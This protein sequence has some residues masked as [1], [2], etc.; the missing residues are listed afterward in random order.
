MFSLA[1][2]LM[3]LSCLL[4][5]LVCAGI[6]YMQQQQRNAAINQAV[7]I[8]MDVLSAY[9]V[10]ID[11]S[12]ENIEASM[13]GFFNNSTDVEI[14][15]R[16]SDD[17]SRLRSKQ[18]ITRTLSQIVQLSNVAECAWVFSPTGNE[19]DYLARNAQNTGISNAELLNIREQIIGIIEKTDRRN[20]ALNARWS[21]MS[22]GNNDY[23]LWITP[24]NDAYCG[25]WVSVSALQSMYD[26]VFSQNNG[27]A[28]TLRSIDEGPGVVFED[29]Y[30]V[31]NAVSER[32]NL[33]VTAMLPYEDILR[34][35][36]VEFDLAL[37]AAGIVA[38]VLLIVL[39]CQLYVISDLKLSVY[40][41]QLQYL[42]IRLKTHF[43]LNCLSIIHAMALTKDTQLITEMT[44]SLSDYL[45]F[46]D[47]GTDQ[48]IKLED[49]LFHVSNYARIQE[50]RFPK[51]FQYTEDV[52]IELYDIKIP[53]LILHTF[54][55][56]SVEH[57]M[58]HDRKNRV[59]IK[60]EPE[61]RKGLPGICLQITDNGKGFSEQTLSCLFSKQDASAQCGGIGIRNVVSR[62]DLI[63]GG[64]AAI[65][66]SN[67]PDGGA[68]ID[69]WLPVNDGFPPDNPIGQHEEPV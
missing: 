3:A 47:N 36:R 39:V 26:G 38:F 27:S 17:V 24:I 69:M 44:E 68:E 67:L 49:E 43:Y 23:M 28:V 6:Y 54:V 13:H 12:L 65:K 7:R 11:K 30:I 32:T 31:I 33:A 34:D 25:A 41:T 61:T 8:N 2:V 16:H 35:M 60:A 56:N 57:A 21:L 1:S 51:L 63:Y 15:G 40:E 48:M 62:L 4:V 58:L 66:F 18:R 53:P 46:L 19:P 52:A 29:D 50:L 20:A 5:I 55:E 14:L 59:R 22:T 45:R 10:D 37:F 64:K 42:R 9:T